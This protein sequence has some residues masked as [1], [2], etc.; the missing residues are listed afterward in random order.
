MSITRIQV[1]S[2]RLDL[3]SDAEKVEEALRKR[4]RFLLVGLEA[5]HL[6]SSLEDDLM[7]RYPPWKEQILSLSTAQR[8]TIL[9]QPVCRFARLHFIERQGWAG[10]NTTPLSVILGQSL[11]EFRTRY[12][13][14]HS[15][16]SGKDRASSRGL[17]KYLSP[18]VRL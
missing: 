13:P 11:I 18:R 4:P 3:N 5:L 12:H 7:V 2:S 9:A 16:K 6:K 14:L 10:V 1:G 15:Y 8:L 17:N